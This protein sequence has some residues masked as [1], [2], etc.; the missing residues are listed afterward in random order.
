MLFCVTFEHVFTVKAWHVQLHK[1]F[2]GFNI[3][4]LT[5]ISCLKLKFLCCV[6][7]QREKEIFDFFF[8]QLHLS[9]IK[10]CS[11]HKQPVKPGIIHTYREPSSLP[12]VV[13]APLVQFPKLGLHQM[14]QCL[15]CCRQ[16]PSFLSSPGE[17]YVFSYFMFHSLSF[18]GGQP[19]ISSKPARQSGSELNQ[20]SRL[21]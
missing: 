19:S 1:E 7:R 10:I 8:F 3:F 15:P 16:R 20:T 18:V 21:L 11:I 9:V 17:L 4:F 14:F 5:E 6:Y 12:Q 2:I 13:S